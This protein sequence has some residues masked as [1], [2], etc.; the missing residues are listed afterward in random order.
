MEIVFKKKLH[1]LEISS[2]F[3]TFHSI[4]IFTPDSSCHISHPH[5]KFQRVR[6]S[7]AIYVKFHCI[8]HAVR[9][10][11]RN[12]HGT[13]VPKVTFCIALIKINVSEI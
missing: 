2:P 10:Y 5:T 7:R 4:Q 8:Q 12:I 11:P 6:E 13:L 1:R 3:N 9:M